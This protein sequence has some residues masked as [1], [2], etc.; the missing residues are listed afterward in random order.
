M[1]MLISDVCRVLD[2]DLEAFERELR[3]FP[4]DNVLWQTTAGVVNPAG[5]LARHV[6]G[7]L[8]YFIGAVLGGIP[9][10]RDRDREF[11]SRNGTRADLVAELEAARRAVRDALADIARV[12]LPEMFPEPVGG[13]PLRT[14][15]FLLH[16]CCHTAFHLGQVGYLRRALMADGRTAGT[17]ELAPLA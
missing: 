13:V 11:T 7:N 4:D 17:M 1:P 3:L 2:R 15:V 6:A 9:Y 16:L 5:A 14:Q 12:P 10:I 8:R